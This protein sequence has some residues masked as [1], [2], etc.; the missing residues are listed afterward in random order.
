ML[1]GSQMWPVDTLN[2]VT[3]SHAG[4]YYT[5]SNQIAGPDPKNY[6][7]NQDTSIPAN[8]AAAG[9][10]MAGQATFAVQAQPNF[11]L[12]FNPTPSYFIAFGN[13]TNGQVLDPGHGPQRR[14]AGVS[15]EHL[16][17]RRHS[18]REQYLDDREHGLEE[19]R[20]CR[21]RQSLRKLRGEPHAA[22]LHRRLHQRR[23]ARRAAAREPDRLS[24]K[25]CSR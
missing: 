25:T 8:M 3:L 7:I 2:Q 17:P 4:G 18:Q 11:T 19:R 20:P 6:Y 5:F 13:Y 14:R 10:G 12:I 9:L 22:E 15:A 24:A 23:G 1:T 21:R 16:F